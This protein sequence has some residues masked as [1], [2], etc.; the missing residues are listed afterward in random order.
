MAGNIQVV[1]GPM[2]SGKSTELIRRIRRYIAAQQKC[3]ILKYTKDTRYHT[4]NIAT[5]DQIMCEAIPCAQLRNFESTALEHDVIGID[6]G[7]FFPDIAEFCEQL[8]NAGKTVIVAALDGDFRRQPF[9]RILDLIPISEDV[10]K[11]K[12]VCVQC[13]GDASFSKRIVESEQIE[14]IGGADKYI[15]SCRNC[16][17]QPPIK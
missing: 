6:E 10:L 16:F 14:L 17:R 15:A 2:F 9:G 7:Q 1:L 11:L 3:L 8:A 12:A 5:H 13:H 4:N